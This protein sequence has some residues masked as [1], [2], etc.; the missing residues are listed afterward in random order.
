MNHLKKLSTGLKCFTVELW[1]NGIWTL[2]KGYFTKRNQT[3][4]PEQANYP[5]AFVAGLIDGK[6]KK[7][8]GSHCPVVIWEDYY[9]LDD[10]WTST[11]FI[12]TGEDCRRGTV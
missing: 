10:E 5:A 11:A 12:I 2:L 7:T 9:T 1:P 6:D 4:A 8:Y 3:T